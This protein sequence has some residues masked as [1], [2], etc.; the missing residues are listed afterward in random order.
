MSPIRFSIIITCYNQREFIR[1]AVE[2]ALAQPHT[3][4][5][6][7]VVDDASTDGSVEQLEQFANSIRLI[8]FT[9]NRGAIEARNEGARQAKGQYLVFLDGDDVFRRWALHAYECLIVERSPKIIA[10]QSLWFSGDVPVHQ[11]ER[12]RVLG[13]K[14]WV[15][16]SPAGAWGASMA[17]LR[18]RGLD[19]GAIHQANICS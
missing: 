13:S 12:V 10:A 5:E 3:L 18:R 9:T 14:L 11:D 2:S 8:K 1:A 19:L 16:M 15:N 17:R 6:I 4:K 7:I